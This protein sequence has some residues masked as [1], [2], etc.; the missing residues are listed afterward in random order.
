MIVINQHY[1]NERIVENPQVDACDGHVVWSPAKSIWFS[2]MAVTA[3]VGGVMTFSYDTVLVF[4]LTTVF[5]LCFGHSLGMHRRLIHQSY[6]CPRWLEYFMVHLGVL[7]G[8]AGPRGMMKTHDMRDWAQRQSHCHD[9]FGHQQP[10]YI[11]VWWQLHCDLVLVNPPGFEPEKAFSGD[12]V[13]QWMEKTWMLQQ[14][15][16]ALLL[17][18]IG[19]LPWVIWGICVRVTVSILGHWLIGFFAHNHGPRDWQV[20]GAAIQ[21]HNV[22][23]T[24]LLTMGECWHNNHHAFPGSANM[25]LEPQQ[26][27]PGWWVLLGLRRLDLVSALKLPADLPARIEL[28]RIERSLD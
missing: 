26:W 27:D 5:T 17:L 11:D 2:L 9:Y 3:V 14:L 19:G 12:R 15:P 4:V 1:T 8:L 25:G 22:R 20:N 24:A 10:W 6:E 13:Y 23:F 18:M 7:V 16:W 28:Q 21:G